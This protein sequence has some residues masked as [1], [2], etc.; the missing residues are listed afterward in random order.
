MPLCDLTQAVVEVLL[1][2]EVDADEGDL[3]VSPRMRVTRLSTCVRLRRPFRRSSPCRGPCGPG[4]VRPVRGTPCRGSCR[5][6]RWTVPERD[7]EAPL[8]RHGCRR[9]G[10]VVA[11]VGSRLLVGGGRWGGAPCGKDDEDEVRG[12]SSA[13]QARSPSWDRSR[14]ASR[15]RARGSSRPR[16]PRRI[17]RGGAAHPCEGLRIDERAPGLVAGSAHGVRGGHVPPACARNVF[18]PKGV[19]AAGGCRWVCLLSCAARGICARGST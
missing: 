15:A 19:R 12:R 6:L 16:G 7:D 11:R 17:P 10:V 14:P 13:A 4:R 1:V 2:P 3:C 9:S 8:P 18:L 5:S